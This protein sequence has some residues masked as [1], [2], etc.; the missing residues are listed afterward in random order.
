MR[1]RKTLAAIL[2]I[3]YTAYCCPVAL[4]AS[5]ISGITPEGNTYNIEADKVSGDTGFRSYDTF[6]LDDGDVANLNFTSKDLGDYGS[7]INMVGS[8]VQINGIVNTV[9]GSDFFGGRA[10]FVSPSGIV[11]GATGVLNVGSLNL[12]STSDFDSLK[13]AYD[14][15]AGDID[16]YSYGADGYKGLVSDANGNIVMSGAVLSRDEV[17]ADASSISVGGDATTVTKGE[18]GI[19]AGWND[20]AQVFDK[21]QSAVW[22]HCPMRRLRNHRSR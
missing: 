8:E 20:D 18:N 5:T 21:R 19:V 6:Q 7:F 11:I 1:I 4:F 3:I 9:R 15:T 22:P 13:N 16:D 14:G 10:I 17:I 12:L 2:C